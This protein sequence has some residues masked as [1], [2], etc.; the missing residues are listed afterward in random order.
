MPQAWEK[1]NWNI[2][3]K[4]KKKNSERWEENK[5]YRWT[6]SK[7]K[8]KA[9]D[10]LEEGI[11]EDNKNSCEH[12]V[13]FLTRS[14]GSSRIGTE[15]YCEAEL[16]SSLSWGSKSLVGKQILAIDPLQVEN[17]WDSFS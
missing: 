1:R 5:R 17:E 9:V 16:V 15:F 13:L 10:D 8:F 6:V 2:E 4:K 11:K 7:R 14:S 3:M 12:K